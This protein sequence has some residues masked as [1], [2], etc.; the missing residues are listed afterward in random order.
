MIL[1]NLLLDWSLLGVGYNE[2]AFV[3]SGILT[4]SFA[5]IVL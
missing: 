1:A 2:K 4:L 3:Q 5:S